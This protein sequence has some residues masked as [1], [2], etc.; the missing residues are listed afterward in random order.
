MTA[1]TAPTPD[2]TTEQ[3]E[4]GDVHGRRHDVGTVVDVREVAGQQV[5]VLD[6]W[7]V[8]GVADEKLAKDGLPVAPFTG[9]RFTNQNSEKTY[10]VPVADS[11]VLVV[12][13]CQPSATPG[14][15]P[16]LSSRRGDLAEL[17][18]SPDL[19]RQVLLL[20]YD[21]GQLVQVDTPPRCA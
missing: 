2:A 11:A 12:N 14:G 3:P 18:G 9:D 7:T 15:K 8:R 16:G 6:R 4:S 19:G 13:E 20:T 17:L 21:D 5:L 1:T 10:A